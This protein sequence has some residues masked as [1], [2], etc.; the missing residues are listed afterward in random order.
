MPHIYKSSIQTC[1]GPFFILIVLIIG[2]GAS[3]LQAQSLVKDIWPGLGG[4]AHHG[5]STEFINIDGTLFFPGDDGSTGIELWKSDGTPGGT[6]LVK[7]IW[8]GSGDSNPTELTNVGGTLFFRAFGSSS[9]G[10]LWTSDGTPGGTTLVKD[11]W[12]GGTSYP[13]EL[14]NVNGTLFFIANDGSTGNELWTSDGTPG[15]TVL[16]KDI[17]PGSGSSFPLF[18]P[19]STKLINVGGTLFFP[20]DDGSTGTE[21]W[22]SDGTESGTTLVKDINSGSGNSSPEVL[23]DVGGTLFFAAENGSTGHELWTSDGTSSGTALVKDIWPGPTPS[24]LDWLTNVGGTLFFSASDGSIGNELWTSDGT[25]S[26]TIP[27]EDINSGSADSAPSRLTNVGGTLFFNADDGSNGHELWKSDGTSGGTLL[28]KNISFS[29][30]SNPVEL[31]DVDGTL[32]FSARGGS[33]PI[34]RELWTSDGTESG[35]VLVKDINPGLDDSDPR[36]LINVN[37][38]LFFAA[39]DGSTGDELWTFDGGSGAP[40]PIASDEQTISED[41]LVSFAGTGISINFVGTSGSG[42]VLVE[43]YDEAPDGTNGISESHIAPYSFVIEADAGLTFGPETEI[44]IDLSTL[45]PLADPE[46]IK[47]YQRDVQGEGTF[48]ELVMQVEGP[49][50]VASVSGFSEFGLAS[51]EPFSNTEDQDGDG[52]LDVADS[53]PTTPNPDQEDADGDGLG[54]A[55]DNCPDIANPDQADLDGDDVGDECDNCISDANP[56][57]TDTDG[58]GVGDACAACDVPTIVSET[59]NNAARTV[60]VVFDAEDPNGFARIDFRTPSDDPALDNFTVIDADGFTTSN[61]IDYTPPSPSPVTATFVLEADPGATT[62]S[63][64]AIIENDCGDIYDDDPIHGF[65]PSVDV[66]ALEAVYPNP[67][68]AQTTVAF[69]LPEQAEV[70][71]AVYDI[72]GRRVAMLAQGTMQAGRHTIEWDGRTQMGRRLASGLYLVRMQAGR[73]TAIHRLTL[74]R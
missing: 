23:T 71:L 19:P 10:E 29:M 33:G 3:P 1:L 32:F 25:P 18:I 46:T 61:N 72:M 22:T 73:F 74:V 55:C 31:T 40:A 6:T 28:V 4:G 34:G 16:V 17:N 66:F 12:P 24:F 47:L 50:L 53:C 11:I 2:L 65:P 59:K 41:G 27:V 38:T 39:D 26:G 67:S 5:T 45:S 36:E 42:S 37:G 44:R 70:T 20:A 51:N 48:T 13:T 54:D 52:F 15:G 8:P 9:G 60:T 62:A 49:E 57:Q 56:D 43:K 35:T 14:T 58:D 7:D 63:Y 30:S 21:L 64:F 69:A 68:R